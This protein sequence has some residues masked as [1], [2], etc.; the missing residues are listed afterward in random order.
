MHNFEENKKIILESQ[1]KMI[2][3]RMVEKSSESAC[4]KCKTIQ[5][6]SHWFNK[7]EG[8]RNGIALYRIDK[9]LPTKFSIHS[10]AKSCRRSTNLTTKTNK[11]KT[12]YYKIK[13]KI[14]ADYVNANKKE[15]TSNSNKYIYNV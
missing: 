15:E 8:K 10:T 7:E 5:I 13:E 2:I 4:K 12:R 3:R 6:I 14:D 11:T 9:S 1:I